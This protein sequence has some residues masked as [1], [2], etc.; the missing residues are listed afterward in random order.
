VRITVLS[1]ASARDAIGAASLVLDLRAGARVADACA[2]LVERYA[3][4][5]PMVP[6]LRFA[7][8]EEFVAAECLLQDGDTL[9]L[10]PPVSGG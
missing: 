10:L 3:A 8:A 9:A 2:V 6:A 7:V 1:F 4:L 5:A